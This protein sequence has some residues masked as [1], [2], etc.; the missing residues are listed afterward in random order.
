MLEP[1]YSSDVFASIGSSGS[2]DIRIAFFEAGNVPIACRTS[3]ALSGVLPG[4]PPASASS[5]RPVLPPV[6]LAWP[7]ASSQYPCGAFVLWMMSSGITCRAERQTIFA[8]VCVPPNVRSFAVLMAVCPGPL[9][10]RVSWSLVCL[11]RCH[12][13]RIEPF[14]SGH[15]KAKIAFV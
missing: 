4:E 8:L 5:S 12:R 15:L 2:F 6:A 3:S 14:L 10:V 1:A 7:A 11:H 9:I 13:G